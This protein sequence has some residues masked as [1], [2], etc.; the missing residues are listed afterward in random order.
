LDQDSLVSALEEMAHS[1]VSVVEILCIHPVE[2]SHAFGKVPI[3]SFDKKMVVVV[4]QTVGV[5]E[6]VIPFISFDQEIQEGS[7]ILI[8]QEYGFLFVATRS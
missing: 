8:V 7:P 3:W 5:T 6:P 2:L 1:F 4:H